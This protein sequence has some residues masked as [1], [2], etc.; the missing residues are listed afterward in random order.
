MDA[1]FC[2][3]ATAA[4]QTAE[5]LSQKAQKIDERLKQKHWG[6]FHGEII[7]GNDEYKNS[8]KE[9][10]AATDLKETAWE[11]LT[12]RFDKEESPEETLIQVFDRVMDLFSEISKNPELK[13]REIVIVT[14]TPVLK[15]FSTVMSLLSQNQ[16]IS[17]HR[18]DFENGGMIVMDLLPDH[19]PVLVDAKGVTFRAGSKY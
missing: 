5:I 14:H 15:V 11:K 4:V 1:V 3:P 17:Y 13:G 9:G 2:S 6:K 7:D 12:F 18:H 10:E 16:E 8:R 19:D